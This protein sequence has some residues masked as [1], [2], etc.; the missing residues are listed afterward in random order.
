MS[1][2]PGA[3]PSA[4]QLTSPDM[5]SMM[6]QFAAQSKSSSGGGAQGSGSPT[7]GAAGSSG[8][9]NSVSPS[10]S[11]LPGMSGSQSKSSAQS[12]KPPRNVDSIPKEMKMMVADVGQGLLSALPDFMQSILHIN[13]TD[14][15]EEKAKKRQSIQKFNS[16]SD[17][18]RQFTVKKYQERTARQKQEQQQEQQRKAAQEN[19]RSSAL[20]MPKGQKKGVMPG[21]SGGGKTKGQSMTEQMLFQQRNTQSGAG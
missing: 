18:D 21:M 14:T 15:P 19:S 9:Q 2:N 20:P 1:D 7:Q 4:G 8:P 16:L 6:Q 12:Q 17:Q 10:S 3:S 13:S 11:S 5:A